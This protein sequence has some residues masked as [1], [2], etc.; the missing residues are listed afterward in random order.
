MD[1]IE[2]RSV[3][4]INKESTSHVIITPV[5]QFPWYTLSKFAL[6]SGLVITIVTGLIVSSLRSVTHNFAYKLKC[7]FYFCW[8]QENWAGSIWK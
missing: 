4:W 6:S 8:I 2:Q 7:F 3:A 5:R 1:V